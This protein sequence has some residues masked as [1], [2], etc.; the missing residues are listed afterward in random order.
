MSLRTSGKEARL[1]FLARTRAKDIKIPNDLAITHKRACSKAVIF[2]DHF[3]I[4][5]QLIES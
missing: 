5:M 3:R 4:I 2:K 1:N